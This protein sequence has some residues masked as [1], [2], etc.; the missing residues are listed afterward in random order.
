MK[1]KCY[2][3][4]RDNRE[5]ELISPLGINLRKELII[6]YVYSVPFMIHQSIYF[7]DQTRKMSWVS[8]QYSFYIDTIPGMTK[9]QSRELYVNNIKSEL[10]KFK[11]D[12]HIHLTFGNDKTKPL[13]LNIGAVY[14]HRN[15]YKYLPEITEYINN[16]YVTYIEDDMV[17]SLYIPNYRQ[18]H[19][20]F[21]YH[22]NKNVSKTV[23]SYLYLNKALITYL[24]SLG[25]SPKATI[26][27]LKRIA[28]G[29]CS[30]CVSF[31]NTL[32]GELDSKTINIY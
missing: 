29:D 24:E 26:K 25:I 21:L 14:C 22:R 10:D 20:L 1:L 27:I 2:I 5:C 32:T 7:H 9:Q 12:S 28:N 31:T 17:D 6:D 30:F 18:L 23:D 4:N 13:P 11:S 19:K 15:A 3:K 16:K 8:L